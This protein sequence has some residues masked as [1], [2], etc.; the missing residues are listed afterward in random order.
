LSLSP[1]NS[2]IFTDFFNAV[3]WRGII[4]AHSWLTYEYYVEE[5]IGTGWIFSNVLNLFCLANEVF[6]QWLSLQIWIIK[7]T[8]KTWAKSSSASTRANIQSINSFASIHARYLTP[9]QR[10][11][12]SVQDLVK[13]LKLV[14][15]NYFLWVLPLD[16]AMIFDTTSFYA[17]VLVLNLWWF[18]ISVFCRFILYFISLLLVVV[19]LSASQKEKRNFFS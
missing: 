1:T 10:K 15:D 7:Q 16:P 11:E 4:S 14:I 13:G 2:H 3:V 6:R 8:L 12:K 5:N 17:S 9:Q 19:M 18:F